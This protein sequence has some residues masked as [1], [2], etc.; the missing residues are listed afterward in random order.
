MKEK[1]HIHNYVIYNKISHYDKLMK[2]NHPIEQP[3][4]KNTAFKKY[5]ER[6]K[7]ISYF[8]NFRLKGT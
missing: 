6:I 2:V 7:L 5:N 1:K 8:P 4:Q 3:Q